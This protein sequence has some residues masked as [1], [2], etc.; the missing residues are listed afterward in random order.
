ML[1]ARIELRGENLFCADT[2]ASGISTVRR[3][4]PEALARL[5]GWAEDYDKA[6]RSGA[7][8]ALVEIGRGIAA[9]LDEGDRWLNQVL[10]G[11]GEIALDIAVPGRPEERER[12]L[13]DVPWELLAP[14]G[15]FLASD[16]ERLFRVTRR[17]GGTGTPAAPAYRDLALLFMAAEVDGQGILSYEREEVAILEATKGLALNLTVEES[18]AIGFL[19]QRIA[20]DGPFEALHLSCHGNIVKN[21][22]FICFETPE[23]GE[24]RINIA[25]LS[26]ALGEEGR[27]RDWSFCPHAAPAS[28]GRLR[29][30]S[31]SRWSDRECRTRSAGTG[32]SMIQTRSALPRRSIE[33]WAPAARSP[34]LRR[35]AGEFCYGLIWPIQIAD[36]IGIWLGLMQ[37]H[38]AAA[39]S[40][41]RVAR[42]ALSAGTRATRNFS[43]SSNGVCR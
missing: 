10:G 2:D 36:G 1:N 12:I 40:A 9:L 34:T 37:D 23:G 8:P 31:S 35:K 39:L 28:T 16:N 13:L 33:S 27:S 14:N 6:V 20:Q 19:G 11:V 3:L 25:R 18:G 38:A 30:R 7:L 5:R 26:D 43:T 41:T 15:F 24:D 29:L 17:I 42:R 22:P 4:T 21:E 32:R